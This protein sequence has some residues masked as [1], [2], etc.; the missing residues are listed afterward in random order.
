MVWECTSQPSDEEER[1][2]RWAGKRDEQ[3]IE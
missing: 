2:N 1:M 3:V